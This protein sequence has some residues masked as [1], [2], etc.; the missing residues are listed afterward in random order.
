MKLRT[1]EI[2]N[3]AAQGLDTLPVVDAARLLEGLPDGRLVHDGYRHESSLSASGRGW[4]MRSQNSAHS[5]GWELASIT[6]P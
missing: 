4:G 3:D 5:P 2:L 1:T 6:P